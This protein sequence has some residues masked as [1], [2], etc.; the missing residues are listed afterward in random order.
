MT[1]GFKTTLVG[2]LDHESSRRGAKLTS[3][4]T[5]RSPARPTV[6]S[7]GPHVRGAGQAPPASL[8]WGW[9]CRL[10]LTKGDIGRRERKEPAW[11]HA[12]AKCQKWYLNR[13]KLPRFTQPRNDHEQR[14]SRPRLLT[15]CKAGKRIK[16]KFPYFLQKVLVPPWSTG[17]NTGFGIIRPRFQFCIRHWGVYWSYWSSNLLNKYKGQRCQPHGILEDKVR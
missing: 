14:H 9:H 8:L 3:K 17:R 6:G 2:R 13:G 5:W 1:N 4:P 10:P 12:L 16:V 15:K 11:G 7:N